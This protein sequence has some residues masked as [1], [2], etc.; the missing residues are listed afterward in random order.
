LT[1]TPLTSGGRSV[2]IVG[3]RTKATE[4]EE[5]RSAG[6]GN[7]NVP[8]CGADLIRKQSGVRTLRRKRKKEIKKQKKEE[9]IGILR[10]IWQKITTDV[11]DMET[12]RRVE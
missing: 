4:L 9:N 1:L 7:T 10:K 8:R 11:W 12:G 3:S 2:G 5:T 6:M